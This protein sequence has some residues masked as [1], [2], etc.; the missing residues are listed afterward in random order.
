METRLKS[1]GAIGVSSPAQIKR[2]I[3]GLGS[4]LVLIRPHRKRSNQRTGSIGGH[5][6]LRHR[7]CS[8]EDV[9][10]LDGS[11]VALCNR[12]RSSNHVYSASAHLKGEIRTLYPNL[13]ILHKYRSARHFIFSPDR[14]CELKTLPID[15]D[16]IFN[17]ILAA[18]HPEHN[19]R[20]HTNL[21]DRSVC[22]QIVS[23]KAYR[24]I[25][26]QQLS[27]ADPR[28]SRSTIEENYGRGNAQ[29]HWKLSDKT[30]SRTNWNLK[31]FTVNP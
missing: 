2:S 6:G 11:H 28:Q 31:G 10:I 16:R 26:K 30:I 18:L 14:W 22:D 5:S 20:N 8:N 12:N 3:L 23:W 25:L 19:L 21:E 1:I 13:S 17:A 4:D 7:S 24:W 29:Y 27:Q 9:Y 15:Y